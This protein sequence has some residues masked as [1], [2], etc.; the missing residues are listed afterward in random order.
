MKTGSVMDYASLPDDLRR[1]L[2]E[3]PTPFFLF[4]LNRMASKM[5]LLRNS[6]QPEQLYYAVKCNGLPHLT[7]DHSNPDRNSRICF[8]S[9]GAY[10]LDCIGTGMGCGFNGSLLPYS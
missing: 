7:V 4:D 9:T 1:R 10:T 2:A 3:L 5:D 6:L 8:A